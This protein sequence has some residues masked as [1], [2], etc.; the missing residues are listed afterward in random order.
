MECSKTECMAHERPVTRIGA[1]T[2]PAGNDSDNVTSNASD[3][4]DGENE[5]ITRATANSR[6]QKIF[7]KFML[8]RF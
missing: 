6:S 1:S 4:D 5:E 2:S 8:P 3:S 7:G